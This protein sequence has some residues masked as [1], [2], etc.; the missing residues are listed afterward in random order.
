MRVRARIAG[1][2]VTAAVAGLLPLA[3]PPAVAA[4]A[5]PGDS[6]IDDW[7]VTTVGLHVGD[8]QGTPAGGVLVSV[9]DDDPALGN[10]LVE[11]D[12]VDGH[13]LRHVFVGSDPRYIA[14]SP[15]G[16]SAYVALGIPKVVEVDLASFTV[17]DEIRLGR[18]SNDA[19]N[20]SPYYAQD[21]EVVPTEDGDAVLVSMWAMYGRSGVF[22]F[23]DGVRRPVEAFD[24]LDASRIAWVG[25]DTVVGIPGDGAYGFRRLEISPEGIRNAYEPDGFDNPSVGAGGSGVDFVGAPDGTFYE[26]DGDVRSGQDG[27]LIRKVDAEGRVQLDPTAQR[28]T[29]LAGSHVTVV[30]MLTGEVVDEGDVAGLAGDDWPYDFRMFTQ[31][32]VG[33]AAGDGYRV[34]LFGPHQAEA[35]FVPPAL[36]PSR[37]GNLTYSVVGAGYADVVADPVRGTLYAAREMDM[38]DPF[39]QPGEPLVD[40][41]VDEVDPTTGAIRRTLPLLHPPQQLAVSDDGTR[42]YAASLDGHVTEVNLATFLPVRAWQAEFVTP[43]P[44]SE[45]HYVEDLAVRPGHPD[46]VVVGHSVGGSPHWVQFDAYVNGVRR[47]GDAG[48]DL[49][50]FD[51][52]DRIYSRDFMIAVQPDGTIGDQITLQ[53]ETNPAHLAMGPTVDERGVVLDPRSGQQIGQVPPQARMGALGVAVPEQDRSFRLLF[54]GQLLEGSLSLGRTLHHLPSPYFRPTTLVRSAVGYAAVNS[55]YDQD[56]IPAGALVLYHPEVTPPSVTSVD[57]A[58]GPVEGGTEIT[59][60]GNGFTGATS[61]TVGG[62]AATGVEVVS[63]IELTATTPAGTTGTA[64]VRVTTPVGTSPTDAVHATFLY[65]VDDPF[66]PVGPLR[67]LDTRAA[68]GVAPAG[69]STTRVRVAG[70]AGIP[71]ERVEAVAL[72]VTAT[73]SSRDLWVTVWPCGAPKPE[74]SALNLSAAQ[75]TA[76][77]LVLVA[78]GDGGDVCVSPS[79]RT[80]LLVD[81]LGWV[82]VETG[83]HRGDAGRLLDTRMYDGGGLPG[84]VRPPAGTVV[85]IPVRHRVGYLEDGIGSVALNVTATGGSA[86]GYVTAWPCDQ[87]VPLASSLNIDRPGQTVANLVVSPIGASGEVCLAS[88]TATHLVADL[89]GW[90]GEGVASTGAPVRL[91]DTRPGPQRTDWSGSVPQAGQTVEVQVA[92]RGGVPLTGAQTVFLNVTATGGAGAGYLTVWP[93]GQPRPWSSNANLTRAGHT[94]AALTATGLGTGGKVCIWSSVSTHL[95]ADVTAWL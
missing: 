2:L 27:H 81:V 92:G 77:N 6:P 70:R 74:T 52:P 51:G 21:L 88:S 89:V 28:S 48:G 40:L 36:L 18:S 45:T 56:G 4:V 35:A 90:W 83:F 66:V 16:T 95:I 85:R 33:F 43:R 93:C 82:P 78:P 87:P 55:Y 9:R 13:L 80:H 59:V 58:Q 41:R 50:T 63:P 14:L 54:D 61:V 72:S 62:V 79:A 37:G 84:Q 86:P 32:S 91:L 24:R 22:S 19:Y 47:D 57:P 26:S 34:Q 3:A 30:S 11:L 68:G 44:S 8:V 75:D 39:H 23:V 67:L 71:G 94:V 1:V 65:V 31:T 49:I 69:G 5:G 29:Y 42:L 7:T 76:A 73:A 64:S 38:D 60:H 46:T 12:P 17:V 20:G 10:E 25:G 53:G 15:D